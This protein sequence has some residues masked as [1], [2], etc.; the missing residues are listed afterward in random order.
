MRALPWGGGATAQLCRIG[1]SDRLTAGALLA[2]HVPI[3]PA[4]A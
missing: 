4:V 1:A 3:G 2:S